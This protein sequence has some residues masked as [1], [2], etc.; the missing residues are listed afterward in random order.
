MVFYRRPQETTKGGAAIMPRLFTGI[1][2]PRAARDRLMLL[3]GETPG[4][5]WIDPE[6]YHITLRFLGEVTDLLA[7]EY[8][9]LLQE[10]LFEPFELQLQGVGYFGSKRPRAIWAG[11]KPSDE[12]KTIFRAHERAATMV[13]L[14]PE[15]RDFVP[16]VTLARLSRSHIDNIATFV[17]DHAAFSAPPFTVSRTALFSA[18]PGGGGGPYV[19]EDAFPFIGEPEDLE[20]D[21]QQED[22]EQFF[23]EQQ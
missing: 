21:E 3:R 18:R 1:E 10:M 14:K 15:T 5:R 13:G 17:A 7:D 2:I 8:V 11:L 16:H 22:D 9:S 20:D 4:A 6:N 12:L 19:V 23:R